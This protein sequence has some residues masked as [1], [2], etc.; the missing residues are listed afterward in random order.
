MPF[1]SGIRRDRCSC[2]SHSIGAVSART[3]RH[4]LRLDRYETCRSRTHPLSRRQHRQSRRQNQHHLDTPP[5]TQHH[6]LSRSAPLAVTLTPRLSP[7]H[8][9]LSH[10]Q[11]DR[12]MTRLHRDGRFRGVLMLLICAAVGV[13]WSPRPIPP[14]MQR[15]G[16][17]FVIAFAR[18]LI[19]S[20]SS[21]PP[22]QARL[23]FSS[24]R[25]ATRDLHRARRWTEIPQPGRSQEERGVR[26]Q[27]RDAGPRNVIL[28]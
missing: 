19:D 10:R 7:G 1:K 18:P 21:G 24:P 16:E 12:G 4:V 27:S 5:V 28:S 8:H 3:G 26:R 22:I 20:S 17:A 11:M 13:C 15:A 2:R 14:V 23:R 6:R 25:A 9:R